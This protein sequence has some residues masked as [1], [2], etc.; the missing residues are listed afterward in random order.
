V[1]TTPASQS[2]VEASA[3]EVLPRFGVAF[4]VDDHDVT[5]TVTR[6]TEGSGLEA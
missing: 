6:C 5:G 4:L 1:A 3:H 2:L